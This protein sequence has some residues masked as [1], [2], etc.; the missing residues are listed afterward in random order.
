MEVLLA[1]FGLGIGVL[2][3]LHLLVEF[4]SVDLGDVLDHD[5]DI[6]GVKLSLDPQE[7]T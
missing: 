2:E 7:S 4:L 6:L 1:R 3:Q 5:C